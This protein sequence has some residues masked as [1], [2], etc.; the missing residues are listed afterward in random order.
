MQGFDNKTVEMGRA[1][2]QLSRRVLGSATLQVAF[3]AA[4][5]ASVVAALEQSGE[6]RAFMQS[7][8]E[9]LAAYGQRGEKLG[10]SFVSWI[11]D[12]S[13]AIR[14]LQEYVSQPELDAEAE[15]SALAAEREQAL[16]TARAALG[17]YPQPV[18]E[19]FESM[20]RFAQ[21]A[22]V[23]SEDH[24]LYIDFGSI[25]QVRRVL[26]EF[27]RR[28]AVS[29]VLA[30][31]A[32]VFLLTLNELRETAERLQLQSKSKS[33]R[34]NQH[35]LVSARK[36][37]MEHARG[38]TPPPVLGVP[39]EGP[40][41]DDPLSRTVG[42]F[43]GAPPAA[44]EATPDA[45]ILRGG[46]GSPGS[47]RGVARVIRSLVDAELLTKGDILVTATTSPAWT[48]LFATAAAV[49]TDTGG[50]LSHCAVVA[51]EYHIPAVVGTGMATALIA[52]GQL[53][54]VD[55]DRGVVRIVQSA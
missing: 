10:I 52:D 40:P 8:R 55:G 39:P 41:P 49:V 33:T 50:V 32:D 14:Q 13:Q 9:F 36:A 28:F 5:A 11:E 26:L 51:R 3:A 44:P 2:W 25:Y 31:P 48:P 19:Q 45:L 42:R 38:V 4:D 17:G 29:G 30:D 47:A 24:T 54:E 7:L 16:A 21:Q 18:I 37:E 23:I 15:L 34:V 1:L 53:I 27:G 6:G 22:T 43:F 20:L 35:E 46:P 12:P